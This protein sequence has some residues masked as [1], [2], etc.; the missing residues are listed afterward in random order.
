MYKRNAGKVLNNN[1]IT[2]N[3]INSKLKVKCLEIPHC[4]YTHRQT[5]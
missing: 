1:S 4:A 5:V 3:E 2:L